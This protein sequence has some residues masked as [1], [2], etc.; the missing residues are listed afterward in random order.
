MKP[1][2]TTPLNLNGMQLPD[3]PSWFPMAWGWWISVIGM[4]IVVLCA[5]LLIR[6]HR[7]RTASKKAALRLL[8]PQQAN[9]ASSA[10]EI[11]RQVALC[12]YPRTDIAHLTGT[13]WYAFLDA[14][15]SQPLFVENE[16]QWQRALYQKQPSNNHQQ[17]V[18]HCYQWVNEALPPKK[19]R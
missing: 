14:Q 11:V 2:S 18:E 8:S 12:Y 7:Q 6:R 1:T 9:S 4:L 19:R 16:T 3:A 13:E 17:L 15:L 10:I 5:V